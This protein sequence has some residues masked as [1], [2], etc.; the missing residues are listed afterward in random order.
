VVISVCESTYA[1]V[2]AMTMIDMIM[3]MEPGPL[4]WVIG[5][6]PSNAVSVP[7]RSEAMLRA[8][9]VYTK[10]KPLTLYNSFHERR[11]H[12]ADEIE[13]VQ[14]ASSYLT[15]RMRRMYMLQH[16]TIH[17]FPKYVDWV[18]ETFKDNNEQAR[19]R[20]EWLWCT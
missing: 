8:S 10:S 12:W 16:G 17:T 15:G 5:T 7:P 4:K 14:Q 6:E 20:D 13:K 18:R 19:L 1:D 3:T 2:D 11:N 9:K